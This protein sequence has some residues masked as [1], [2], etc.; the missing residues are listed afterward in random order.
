[1]KNFRKYLYLLQLEEYQTQRFLSWLKSHEISELKEKKGKLKWTPR[2]IITALLSFL[3]FL[4]QKEK[5]LANINCFLAKILT[6]VEKVLVFLAKIKISFYP[7]V[8]KIVVTGSYGKTTFKEMLAHVLRAKYQVLETP[9]NVNTLIGI[10]LLI[11]K[12]MNKRTEVFVAEAGAYQRGEIRSISELIRPD[13]GIVTSIGVMH[14]ERFETLENI[15]QAKMEVAD[16]IEDE[17]NLFY[18]KKD[19]QLIGFPETIKKIAGELGF[20]SKMIEERLASFSAPEHRLSQKQIDH[21]LVLIDDSYNS[22]PLGF[23]KALEVLRS[24]KGRQKIVV[25]PGM[26]E[27]GKEQFRLN[28]DLAKKVAEIADVFFVVGRTNLAA[29]KAGAELAKK[30]PLMVFIDRD[31][32]YQEKMQTVFRPPTVVLL[33]NDLPDHYF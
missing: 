29:L 1:M 7:Q 32:S 33:E 25:T 10:A 21:N 30:K 11:L 14:L 27:L 13:F 15:R 6:F 22:N 3:P 4:I 8:V 9:G 28:R 16:F 23:N 24:F 19:H 2:V 20:S 18:P 5:A 17:N 26:I 31:E 12:K